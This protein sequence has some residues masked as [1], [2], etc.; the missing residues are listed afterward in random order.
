MLINQINAGEKIHIRVEKGTSTMEFTTEAIQLTSEVDILAIQQQEHKLHAKIL[1]VKLITD[2]KATPGKPPVAINFP[3]GN[4][5][6]KISVVRD[7]TPYVWRR[8]TIRRLNKAPFHILVS[9]EDAEP[10][11]RRL[12]RRIAL[13]ISG[14]ARFLGSIGT[15][16]ITVKNISGGGIAILIEADADPGIVKPGSLIQD[17][18]FEDPETEDEFKLSAFVLR[19]TKYTSGRTQFACKLNSKTAEVSNYVNH[20]LYLLQERSEESAES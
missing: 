7:K 1:P 3:E 5:I 14:T 11:E 4:I 12:H 19:V 10:A 20:K 2:G 13:G 18:T 9:N 16:P 17:V 15:L 6:Y 8:I